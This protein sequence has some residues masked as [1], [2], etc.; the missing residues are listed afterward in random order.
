[1]LDVS[2]DEPD[3]PLVF[4]DEGDVAEREADV[5][6]VS[7]AEEADVLFTAAEAVVDDVP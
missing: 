4:D 1:V 3:E 6:V 7:F 5:V 2:D